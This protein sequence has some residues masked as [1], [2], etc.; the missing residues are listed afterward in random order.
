PYA[1]AELDFETPFELL[2]ATVLSAQTTDVR[3]NAATPALFARFPDAHAMAAATEPE[4][5]ELVRSTGFYRNKASAILRLS[6]ELV[7]RHDGEVPARL[8]D[9][10][11]LPG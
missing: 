3:V 5:Q 7:G 9:L 10:V 4:L 8:E 6:Q 1:V 2:V 11:A